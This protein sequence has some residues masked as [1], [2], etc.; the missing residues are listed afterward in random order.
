[1]TP[2]KEGDSAIK[3]TTMAMT[4]S[5]KPKSEEIKVEIK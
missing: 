1:M 2:Q 4:Q 5:K 3:E